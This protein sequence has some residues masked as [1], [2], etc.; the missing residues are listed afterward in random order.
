M[1]VLDDLHNRLSEDPPRLPPWIFVPATSIP[2]VLDV[3]HYWIDTAKTAKTEVTLR[4]HKIPDPYA[5][6]PVTMGMPGPMFPHP[7]N[8]NAYNQQLV[9]ELAAAALRGMT[10]QELVRTGLL[11][12]HVSSAQAREY[13]ET[14]ESQLVKVM[15]ERMK[16]TIPSADTD[17][18]VKWYTMTK[19]VP[20]PKEFEARH[21]A[22]KRL[23]KAVRQ[24]EVIPRGFLTQ[25]FPSR[26]CSVYE[27]SPSR[28]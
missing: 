20:I 19:T 17:T 6:T 23:L 22:L 26:Q 25:V 10:G 8:M 9:Q 28:S 4:L 16:A 15:V 13:F 5:Q 7:G 27:G 1:D 21:A 2:P 18:E 14:H 3:I 11:P 24:N 12:D